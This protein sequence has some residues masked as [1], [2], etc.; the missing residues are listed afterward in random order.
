[1]TDSELAA[2]DRYLERVTRVL[3]TRWARLEL[4]EQAK[5]AKKS[6]ERAWLQADPTERRP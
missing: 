2:I 4:A 1:M 5:E 6:E 3:L